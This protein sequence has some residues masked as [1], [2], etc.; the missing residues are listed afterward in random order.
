[1]V[2]RSS[3]PRHPENEAL[4]FGRTRMSTVNA[5][6][7]TRYLSIFL[8]F[9]AHASDHRKA[10]SSFSGGGRSGLTFATIYNPL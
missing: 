1:M 9:P 5:R 7:V 6:K 2:R 8:V 4:P 10:A 3:Y